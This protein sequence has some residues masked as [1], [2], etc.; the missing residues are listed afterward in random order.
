[1]F[2]WPIIAFVVSQ[3]MFPDAPAMLVEF[4]LFLLLDF[5]FAAERIHIESG[6]PKWNMS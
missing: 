3:S 2:E 6:R 4:S 5:H 1:M